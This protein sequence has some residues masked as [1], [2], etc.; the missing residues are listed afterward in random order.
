MPLVTA[1]ITF[2]SPESDAELPS[3][4]DDAAEPLLLPAFADA[5]L[6]HPAKLA[7]KR[8]A[9]ANTAQNFFVFFIIKSSSFPRFFLFR[10]RPG[11]LRVFHQGAPDSS[12]FLIKV[13]SA[14]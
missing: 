12:V 13:L 5:L 9:A 11:C 1:L 10:P 4:E 3:A 2:F 8:P 14:D 7:A 6:P